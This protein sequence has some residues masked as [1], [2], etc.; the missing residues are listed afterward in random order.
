MQQPESPVERFT[1]SV[2]PRVREVQ[3]RAKKQVSA[4]VLHDTIEELQTAMEELRVAQD[5]LLQSHLLLEE[6]RRAH[7]LE[8]GLYRQLFAITPVP[9]LVI[10]EAGTVREANPAASAL[11]RV[12]DQKLR[13]K[14]LVVFVAEDDRRAFRVGLHGLST[15]TG[16]AKLEFRLI[17][18][19]GVSMHVEAEAM[20]LETSGERL[21]LWAMRDL[22]SCEA[23]E[24]RREEGELFRALL[25]SLPQ[26]VAAMDLDGSV[27]AWNPAAE[28]LLGWTEEEVLGRP[29]PA[30]PADARHLV[31]EARASDGGR[32]VAWLR[33]PATAAD[34]GAVAVEV[35]LAPLTGA[36]GESRG[37]VAMIAEAGEAPV[38]AERAGATAAGKPREPVEAARVIPAGQGDFLER[39]RTG[40]AAGL[41]LG[42]LH[43]GDRLPSIRDAARA[44]GADHR[45]VSVAYRQ[46]ASEG[47][48]EVINRRGAM[49]A[50]L[51]GGADAELTESAEWLARVLSEAWQ[52]QVKVPQLP[53]L[54]RDWTGAAPVRCACVEST[55]DDLAA[56]TRELA[57]QWGLA[58]YAVRADERPADPAAERRALADGLRGADLVVTTAFHARTVA[59]VAAALGIPVVVAAMS[60]EVVEAVEE[61]LREGTLTAV[62]ADERWGARLRAAL[63][64]ERVRVVRA[65]DAAAVARLDPSE[66]VLLTRAARERIGAARPRLL[67]PPTHFVSA[68]CGEE[69]ARIVIHRNVEAAR[70]RN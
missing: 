56:L 70:S 45:A 66:P 25:R 22:A 60:P 69:I 27:L 18:R 57:S 30:I 31:G 40:I 54:L 9:L 48:V 64:T 47:V 44:A 43:P 14:P 20:P 61:R 41:H 65:D 24:A 5:E 15:G 38:P 3:S 33:A 29:N 46:L 34:G 7:E 6:T 1:A 63:G 17:P 49:L 52:L 53:A 8:T 42:R 28:R 36:G 62:A 59:P 26:A 10:D 67:V 4:A 35:V 55:D 12:G 32:G 23:S 68:A 50:G 39:L 13:G 21:L 2:Q 37:T 16:G 58:T 51:P 11:L 19:K